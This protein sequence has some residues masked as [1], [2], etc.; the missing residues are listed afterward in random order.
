MSTRRLSLLVTLFLFFPCT[1]GAQTTDSLRTYWIEPI[2]IVGQRTYVGQQRIPVEKDNLSEVLT[3]NG[4]KL[5]RKGVFFAQ[6]VYADGLKR[7][8]ISVV[9]DGERYHSACPN[10]MDSPL[11]RVN[12][13]E[14]NSVELMKTGASVQSGLGGV[15]QFQRRRPEKPVTM[16]AGISTSGAA[17]RSIDALAAAE[18]R[19]HRVSIRYAGGDPYADAEDRTFRDLY[20]YKDNI[21]YRLAEGDFTGGS[22]EVKYGAGFAYTEDVSFPYLQMD[23]RTNEVY[24]GSAAVGGHKVYINY[25][26]HFMDNAMRTGGMRMETR[27]KNV[28][29]GGVG[30]WYDVYFRN[31]DANNVFRLPNGPLHNK[32][33]PDTR[34]FSA[35]LF[36]SAT[37]GRFTFAGKIGGVNHRVGDET[38]LLFYEPLHSEVSADRFFVIYAA[39]ATYAR[40]LRSNCVTALM[41]EGASESPETEALYIAV[42]KPMNK[43]WWSGNPN[44]GQP[45]R[46]TLRGSIRYG[47][48]LLELYGTHI[49]DYVYLAKTQAGGTKY[50]TY[51]NIDAALAGVNLNASWTYLDLRATYTWGENR[52][53]DTPLAEIAPLTISARVKSPNYRGFEGFIES[54]YNDAQMRIDENLSERATSSWYRV[55]LGGNY[56][57]RDLVLT[58]EVGNIT[59]E[60]FYQ[61]LSYLRNPFA[62][63]V[64]VWEPGTTVTLGLRLAI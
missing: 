10:R 60:L 37:L 16:A 56:S 20:N 18:G 43:P 12:S 63:G 61:H 64:S 1:V 34:T 17:K 29:I 6:D 41:L 49:W 9:I 31:W 46:A 8:D 15:V 54:T 51:E 39:S 24:N 59:N 5:I 4:F 27:A 48:A 19:N 26:D 22:G 21:P 13:F 50:M 47:P 45:Y 36:K 44:L 33:I 28:T 52:S 23:E 57:Y 11:T 32:M 14:L 58:L 42:Q 7:G 2:E 30:G 40:A 3:H 55:D 35:A 53:A 38:R 25:T 62:S